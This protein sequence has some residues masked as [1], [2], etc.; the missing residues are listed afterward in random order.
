MELAADC[1]L[2]S[3]NLTINIACRAEGGVRT[4]NGAGNLSH[5][6]N[7]TVIQAVRRSRINNVN[8]YVSLG[9]LVDFASIST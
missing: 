2:V 1:D 4:E 5:G 8:D 7:I 6:S 3:D 9:P